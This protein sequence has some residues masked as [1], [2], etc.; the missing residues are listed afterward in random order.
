MDPGR[1][2]LFDVH[3]HL[4]VISRRLK[5]PAASQD[6]P[7]LWTERRCLLAQDRRILGSLRQIIES[8]SACGLQYLGCNGCCEEDWEQVSLSVEACRPQSLL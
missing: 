8:S 7:L 4:Q 5:F 6:S 3:C 2:K 1:L